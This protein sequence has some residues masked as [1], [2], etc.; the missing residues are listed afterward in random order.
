M[1]AVRRRRTALASVGFRLADRDMTCDEGGTM[2]AYLSIP[3]RE[4]GPS[5]ATRKM[6]ASS[7]ANEFLHQLIDTTAN[8]SEKDSKKA[9]KS[10]NKI[11]K[12]K[13]ADKHA[14]ISEDQK[15]R[16]AASAFSFLVADDKTVDPSLSS[17][18]AVKVWL[19]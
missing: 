11:K 19:Y 16:A 10:E 4:K 18:F 7:S 17:L 15:Q 5:S 3:K 14:K 6:L 12:S 2:L 13:K 1:A 9:K 8:M